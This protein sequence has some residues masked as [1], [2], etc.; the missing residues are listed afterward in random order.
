[1]TEPTEREHDAR[2]LRK[3]L[4]RCRRAWVATGDPLALIEAMSLSRGQPVPRWLAA[5]LIDMLTSG[6]SQEWNERVNSDPELREAARAV[7]AGR[8]RR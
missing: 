8:S 5:A 3:H 6:M 7:I 1:M 4:A 2:E